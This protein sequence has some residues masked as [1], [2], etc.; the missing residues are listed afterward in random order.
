VLRNRET[1]EQSRLTFTFDA[2]TRSSEL[3]GI[4]LNQWQWNAQL[5]FFGAIPVPGKADWPGS[6][7]QRV[8][9]NL[10]LKI[11]T[12]SGGVATAVMN[13]LFWMNFEVRSRSVIYSDGSTDILLQWKQK[14]EL[15]PS[16]D[17]LGGSHRIWIPDFGTQI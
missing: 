16:W 17:T 8:V 15:C 1:L 10:T 9:Y 12:L 11:P 6:V 7:D 3:L 5:M 13:T 4:M 2:T 14:G